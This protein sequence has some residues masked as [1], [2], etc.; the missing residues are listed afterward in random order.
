MRLPPKKIHLNYLS[1]V[2]KE[3]HGYGKST[4]PA[5]LIWL[6]VTASCHIS[7]GKSIQMRAILSEL[8]KLSNV[9]CA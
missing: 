7:D 6:I 5:N 1:E 2:S 8:L 9:P 3:R 4:A